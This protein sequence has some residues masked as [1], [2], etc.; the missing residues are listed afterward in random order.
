MSNYQARQRATAQRL[1]KAL[2]KEYHSISYEEGTQAELARRLR[3]VLLAPKSRWKSLTGPYR[4]MVVGAAFAAREFLWYS[5]LPMRSLRYQKT[6]AGDGWYW[7]NPSPGAS[8]QIFVAT[9]DEG[10]QH[11]SE[12]QPG[13]GLPFT[14]V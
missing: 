2:V 9:K 3:N 11:Y 4:Q 8:P 1:I 5:G 14:S 10:E 13:E 6:A 12:A 7:H